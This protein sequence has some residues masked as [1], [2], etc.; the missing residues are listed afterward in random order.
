MFDRKSWLTG[1]ILGLAGKPLSLGGGKEPVAYLYNGVRLPPLPEWDNETYP[2]AVIARD[3]YPDGGALNVL[4]VH[5][6]PFV[7][8]DLTE[9]YGYV[10]VQVEDGGQY[11]YWDCRSPDDAGWLGARIPIGS[12]AWEARITR[13]IWANTTI[14]NPDDSVYI[15][16][17]EP[18]PVYE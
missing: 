17:S 10:S 4:Y 2:Y 15:D 11:M 3:L 1:F 13:I 9:K 18:V 6:T 7:T 16:A 14:Y 8:S 12:D 5:S